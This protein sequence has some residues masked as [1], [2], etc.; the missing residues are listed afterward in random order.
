[1]IQLRAARLLGRHV[2]GRAADEAG[3]G[4]RGALLAEASVIFAM[5]KSSTFTKSGSPRRCSTMMFSG[6]GPGG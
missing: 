3:A 2:L 5:P 4:E 6:L 1:M